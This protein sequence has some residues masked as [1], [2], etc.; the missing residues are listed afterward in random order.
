M[1]GTDRRIIVGEDI[2]R[3][4]GRNILYFKLK[5]NSTFFISVARLIF[6]LVNWSPILSLAMQSS[7]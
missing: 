3:P 6:L 2:E 4:N 5:L 1:D 7:A